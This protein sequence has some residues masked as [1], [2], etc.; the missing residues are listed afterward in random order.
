MRIDTGLPAFC[1]STKLAGYIKERWN[2]SSKSLNAV[3]ETR[4]DKVTHTYTDKESACYTFKGRGGNS[5]DWRR[6]ENTMKERQRM[7]DFHIYKEE[8][9]VVVVDVDGQGQKNVGYLVAT[10][11]EVMGFGRMWGVWMARFYKRQK[12]RFG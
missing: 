9:D 2:L 10:G 8:V 3:G 7:K 6:E 11:R 1:Q 12:S 4:K 5:Q